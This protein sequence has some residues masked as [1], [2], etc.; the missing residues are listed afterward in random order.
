MNAGGST[1]TGKVVLGEGQLRDGRATFSAAVNIAP[2]GTITTT[3]DKS[4]AA[5]AQTLVIAANTSR[6]RLVVTNPVTNTQTMRIGDNNTGAARGVELPP[7]GV[8]DEAYTGALYA[9][10]PGAGAE[11]LTIMEYS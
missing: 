7:G 1:V 2:Y 3:A 6:K 5:T 9:Y 4:C 11:S 8:F 10:N